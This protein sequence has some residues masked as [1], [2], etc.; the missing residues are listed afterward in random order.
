LN[1]PAISGGAIAGIVIGSILLAGVIAAL[2]MW[3]LKKGKKNA[4]KKVPMK[5]SGEGTQYI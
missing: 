5:V 1:N 2:V 3:L 4:D